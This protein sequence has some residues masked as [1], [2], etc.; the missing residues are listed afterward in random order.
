MDK[1]K[2]RLERLEDWT[3]P[4]SKWAGIKF[5]KKCLHGLFKMKDTHGRPVTL[6][7]KADALAEYLEKVHWAQIIEQPEGKI[8]KT[9][10]FRHPPPIEAGS[11]KVEEVQ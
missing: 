8:D 5:E 6:N 9:L 3:T 1:K 11:I 7:K 4:K 2:W 10:I